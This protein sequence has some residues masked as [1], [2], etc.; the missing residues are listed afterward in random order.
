MTEN[1]WRHVN[2][3]RIWYNLVWS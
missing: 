3:S 1:I 2:C